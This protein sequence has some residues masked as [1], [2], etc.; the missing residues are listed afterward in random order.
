VSGGDALIRVEGRRLHDLRVL[1]TGVD[2][3]DAFT[4]EG[5]ELVG[6]VDG[7]RLGRNRIGVYDHGRRVAKQTLVNNPIEGPIFSGPHQRPFVCKTNQPAVGLG[8]DVTDAANAKWR[9]WD[10]REWLIG[11]NASDTF[12]NQYRGGA[13]GST[14]CVNGWRGLAPLAMNPL[15][16]TAGAGTERWTRP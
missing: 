4:R 8:M 12:P 9:V 15:F 1:R 11:L 7:L 3:T 16:G 6:L 5:G 14:E 13:A 2:V 10:Q